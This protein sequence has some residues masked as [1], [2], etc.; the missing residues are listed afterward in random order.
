MVGHVTLE[1]SYKASKDFDQSQLVL[2]L[3][4]VDLDMSSQLLPWCPDN[5]PASML[6]A[7]MI[8]GS[9]P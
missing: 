2:W 8:I 9:N 3:V 6:P 4:A 7:M 1:G 5:L